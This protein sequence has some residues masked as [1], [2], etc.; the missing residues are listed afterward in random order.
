MVF[1]NGRFYMVFVMD[2]NVNVLMW[3]IFSW[4]YVGILVVL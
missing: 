1:G 2:T 4:I 3:L